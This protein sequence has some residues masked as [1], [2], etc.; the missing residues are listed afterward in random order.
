MIGFHVAGRV[1]GL[2]DNRL[3]V[4]SPAVWQP[5]PF[6]LSLA[7]VWPVL[8]GLLPCNV[9]Q[10]CLL[11]TD[12][13][14]PSPGRLFLT[15]PLSLLWLR[16]HLLACRRGDEINFLSKSSLWTIKDRTTICSHR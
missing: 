9:P 5:L 2:A 14:W 3:L 10:S 4:L 13:C 6:P 11:L 15:S 12:G 7:P 1:Q 16:L 8:L